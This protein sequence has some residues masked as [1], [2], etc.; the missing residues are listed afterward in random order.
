MNPTN[1]F[2][3]RLHF[4][5][6]GWKSQTVCDIPYATD[7]SLDDLAS[8]LPP[9]PGPGDSPTVCTMLYYSAKRTNT[10]AR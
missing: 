2:D 8:R 3:T 1:P 5:E 10:D 7:A 9:L 6:T 4:E